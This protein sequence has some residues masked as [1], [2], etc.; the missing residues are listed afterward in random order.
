M[1]QISGDSAT[2]IGATTNGNKETVKSNE[3]SAFSVPFPII[4]TKY[5][6]SED[7]VTLAVLDI[8]IT[9]SQ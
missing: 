1:K 2:D 8:Y 5:T 7:E 6:F 4:F 9:S 3:I